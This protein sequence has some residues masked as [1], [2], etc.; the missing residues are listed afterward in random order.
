VDAT[1]TKFKTLPDGGRLV[2]SREI[3]EVGDRGLPKYVRYE[4]PGDHR[5]PAMFVDIAM[6]DGVPMVTE[7]RV[8]AD[9]EAGR[10]IRAKDIRVG[11]VEL[12]DVLNRWLSE[13]AY[14]R[15]PTG[16]WR[17]DRIP[18]D[19]RR[20]AMTTIGSARRRKMTPDVLK[21]VAELYRTAPMPR[22]EAIAAAFDVDPRT[23][24]RYIQKARQAGL[25]D[26]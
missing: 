10:P 6:I 24:Q 7:V 25:I 18:P 4:H 17:Y 12:G 11:A 5:R 22:H 14:R 26:G 9:I 15:S 1:V 8:L 21:E 3:E 20:S 19:E 2:Y 13:L 23:A 16:W